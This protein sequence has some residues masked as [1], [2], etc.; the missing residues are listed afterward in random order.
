MNSNPEWYTQTKDQCPIKIFS[1][2]QDVRE[3]SPP[4]QSFFRKLAEDVL[5][6][7]QGEKQD[8]ES[9]GKQGT[10]KKVRKIPRMTMKGNPTTVV[11]L[12]YWATA[13]TGMG[14]R[15]L[16]KNQNRCIPWWVWMNG[17]LQFGQNI[18]GEISEIYIESLTRNWDND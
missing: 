11:V 10:H 14:G 17:D 6:Q 2:L 15:F 4:L 9:S 3:K 18:W 7:N 13:K 16:R 12:A 1:D 8:K 5:Y